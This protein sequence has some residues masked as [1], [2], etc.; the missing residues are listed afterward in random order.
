MKRLLKRASLLTLWFAG[1]LFFLYVCADVWITAPSL[2]TQIDVA[3]DGDMTNYKA[4]Q[5]FRKESEYWKELANNR[6]EMYVNIVN[7]D[8]EVFHALKDQGIKVEYKHKD[9]AE[10]PQAFSEVG[11]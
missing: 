4:F 5:H 11:Q 9:L 8:T 1:P 3:F 2:K 6:G 7:R 10:H